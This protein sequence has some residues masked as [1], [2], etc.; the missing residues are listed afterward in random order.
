MIHS[1]IAIVLGGY[2]LWVQNRVVT[3][4]SNIFTNLPR[5]ADPTVNDARI[6]HC[7]T[8]GGGTPRA[9]GTLVNPDSSKRSLLVTI[10]FL[11]AKG[12]EQCTGSETIRDVEPG[13]TARWSV[14][15]YVNG[16]PASCAVGTTGSPFVP[17]TAPPIQPVT[18]TG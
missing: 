12:L 9:D 13:R 8:G 11:D 16:T 2:G 7:N 3:G 4:L 18:P 6:V 17:P 14:T 1:I 5:D 15:G 10:R